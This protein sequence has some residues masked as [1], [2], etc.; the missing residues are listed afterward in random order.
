MDVLTIEQRRLNMSRI[1]GKDTKPEMLLRRG[2]HAAGLR[3]RLHGA[4]LPGKPDMVFPKHHAVVLIHGCFW[5]GH[6]CPLFK[7]PATRPEFWAKKI[8][9]NR[10][11]DLRTARALQRAG[12]RL[13]TVWECSLRGAARRPLADVVGSCLSFIRGR[14]SQAELTGLIWNRT[15]WRIEQGPQGRV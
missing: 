2:L 8:S 12:W 9:G 14:E 1:R 3:F 5:H 4:Q 7:M 15:N 11:R 10:E 13:L 6:D